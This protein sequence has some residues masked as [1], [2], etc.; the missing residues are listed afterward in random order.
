MGAM[1]S[2]WRNGAA[3]VV[4]ACMAASCGG[5][6]G[7]PPV[8]TFG[9]DVPGA[10]RG[11]PASC[12]G[13]SVCGGAC[14]DLQRDPRHCGGCD[15]DCT[16]L[17]HVAADGVSCVAGRCVVAG[18]CE[19][20]WLHCNDNPTVGCEAAA[21]DP[22]HCGSCAVSCPSE[23]PMCRLAA[24]P[25]DAGVAPDADLG[26]ASAMDAVDVAAPDVPLTPATG[27]YVCGN[28]CAAGEAR[29]GMRCVDL[30]NDPTRCGACDAVPCGSG[31]NASPA[32][33]AGVC[34]LACAAGLGDC[35]ADA[36]NGCE[37]ATATAVTHCGA[38][39]RVCPAGAN[40]TPTCA[41]GVCGIACAAG[42]GDCDA[43]A[44][45]GCE[46]DLRSAATSCGR[47]G[48]RCPS[49][50]NAA[51]ACV[52]GACALACAAGFGNCDGV[53]GNGCEVDTA[54]SATN[55]GVC[56]TAC[57]I[58]GNQ[59]ARCAAG[60]CGG[61]ACLAGFAD[62]DGVA[63]NGCEVT[64][65]SSAAHC[66][67]CGNACALANAVAACTMGACAVATCAAGFSD[68]DAVTGTGCEVDT[69]SS[70]THCG[71]CGTVCPARA[72]ATPACVAAAC[73]FTCAPGFADCDG[74]AANGCEVDTRSSP[75]HCG[76]CG[77]ACPTRPNAVATCAASVCG[78]VCGP[79]TADCDGTT[80][81]GCE[82]DTQTSVSH[83]GGCGRSC[84]V[85]TD[86]QRACAASA[87]TAVCDP[88]RTLDGTAC[89][90]GPPQMMAP[91]SS[92]IVTS[93]RPTL[94]W[95]P[96]TGF[97]A[98]RVELFSDRAC[99]RPLGTFM[100][101][102]QAG[103]PSADLPVGTAFWRL[104]GMRAGVV[105]SGPSPVWQ[106]LVRAR[107]GAVDTAWGS[108]PDFNG[109]GLSDLVIGSQ[110]QVVF[111]HYGRTSNINATPDLILT[112]PGNSTL[113]GF[114]V[115]SVGDINGDGFSDLA[116]GARGASVLYLYPGGP[117]GLQG[118][119]SATLTG[120]PGLNFGFTVSSAG[121]VNRDGFGDFAVGI[122]GDLMT[123]AAGGSVFV[124]HG[125]ATFP[126]TGV[127]ANQVISAPPANAPFGFNVASAG[128]TDGDGDEELLIGSPF[129][130]AFFPNAA[131]LYSSTGAAFGA[132]PTATWATAPGSPFGPPLAT[133]FGYPAQHVGDLDGDGY[134]D[135]AIGASQSGYVDVFRG[136]PTGL[137]LVRDLRLDDGRRDFGRSVSCAGDVNGDG[138]DDLL[139][140]TDRTDHAYFY[141]G[142]AAGLRVGERVRIDGDLI[143]QFG[144]TVASPGDLNGDGFSDAVIGEFAGGRA[145]VFM[146]S[147]SGLAATPAVTI[148]GP[149]NSNLSLVIAGL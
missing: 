46:T 59:Q 140:G 137:P 50:T 123:A 92:A 67:A 128:D 122:P 110:G 100:A 87:C 55:C 78:S 51:P 65:A 1:T 112:A 135:V 73:R 75:A 77:N 93:R 103:R 48:N 36:A 132:A 25:M 29:C 81:N 120:P 121:D 80:A 44:A 8:A 139:V 13:G 129:A 142:G 114:A 62:C 71:A 19:P 24:A 98:V 119:P 70:A 117:T 41:A 16:G 143:R 130:P 89:L 34:A 90:P 131:F 116:V 40:A 2:A 7:R 69:R 94:R 4:L 43:D 5:E 21:G 32:C 115:A 107:G 64:L 12:E 57:A 144:Y 58:T 66:G 102:T 39:G 23:R 111:V 47:C 88:G 52:E 3:G 11:A 60:V 15:T 96:I 18:A 126:A 30:Q 136:R 63:S 148:V 72:N 127:T 22:E 84:P 74:V 108:V 9:F 95:G 68:C 147:S 91:I 45:N 26:D 124:F 105:A 17:P 109:D 134:A 6:T 10:D 14:V 28:D 37:T 49:Q 56:G 27:R 101:T 83:C 33:R 141:P 85:V 61:G 99:T 97:D 79:G 125:R 53:A 35:D 149:T 54:S 20:G 145:R 86:G 138:Y 133:F 42:F 113:F 31:P 106:L 146:G 38:C 118:A 104:R 82:S 76:S